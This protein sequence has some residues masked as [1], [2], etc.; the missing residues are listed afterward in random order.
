MIPTGLAAGYESDGFCVLDALVPDAVVREAIAGQDA[1][2]AG[3]YETSFRPALYALR[4]EDPAAL[5]KIDEAHWCDTRIWN[6]VTHPAIGRAAAE[7]TGADMVQVWATQLLY[8]PPGG[9]STQS[10]GWHQDDTYWGTWWDGEVFTCWVALSDVGPDSGPVCFV[11]G[12]HRWGFIEGGDFFHTDLE[13]QKGGYA[14]PA[15][16]SWEEVGALM[17]PGGASFHHRR[18]IHGSRPN[19]SGEPRRSFAV[20]LRTERS[21]PRD[22]DIHFRRAAGDF[23]TYPVIYTRP[24]S[25]FTARDP[26]LGVVPPRP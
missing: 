3:R 12:S 16:A 11:R 24:G 22:T 21:N 20:H 8:K 6:L 10:V 9:R 15:G 18:T 13:S 4:S 19:T 17:P 25:G 5:V 23:E 14:K 7:L 26:A 1:V 2:I